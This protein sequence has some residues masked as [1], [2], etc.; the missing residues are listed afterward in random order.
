MTETVGVLSKTIY[1]VGINDA[2]YVVSP[3]LN[4]NRSKCHYYQTWK[5]M[6]ERCYSQE[7]QLRRTSYAGCTVSE[8]WHL[9]SSFKM[10]M[11]KQDW[12]GKELDKDILKLNNKVYSPSTCIFIS[13][14]IN[15]LF[16]DRAASRGEYPQG[17][18]F[19]KSRGKFRASCRVDGLLK[20]LGSFTTSEE[21]EYV[22]LVFK[23]GLIAKV[24]SAQ[25]S[26]GNTLLRD[27]LITRAEVFSNKANKLK[28]C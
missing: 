8:E 25:E 7:F 24:I 28:H 4:G 12:R 1:G 11:Q 21:A 16:N 2:D 13:G 14:A 23:A 15:S 9:F 19:C 18:S 17:V 5:G 10:W 26:L 6:L 22:Y 3:T 27:A 20:N